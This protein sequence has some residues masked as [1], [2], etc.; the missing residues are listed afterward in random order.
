MKLIENIERLGNSM[1]SAIK[2]MVEEMFGRELSNEEVGEIVNSLKLSDIL[3]LDTA[4]T[5]SDKE[6]VASILGIDELT[7]YSMGRGKASSQAASRPA[8]A[9]R[10]AGQQPQKEP[11]TQNTTQTNRNYSGGAQNAV[12][13]PNIDNEDDPD[14]VMQDPEAVEENV[15]DM[16]EWLQRKAGIK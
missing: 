15:I 13:T 8:P 3:V 16:V 11:G 6:R 9:R 10:P 14:A 2:N 5:Q 7:E 1:E 12:T 4:Y